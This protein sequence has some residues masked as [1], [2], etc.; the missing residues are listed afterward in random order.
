[1][2]IRYSI[3]L[4]LLIGIPSI[5]AIS[6]EQ[7]ARANYIEKY[8]GLAVQEMKKSGIP[9]SITMA[10]ALLESNDGKSEMALTAKNHFGI[11][12]HT[13]WEGRRFYYDDD[14]LNDCFRV[15]KKIKDSYRD[16]SLFLMTRSRY[17]SLFAENSLF[18][19][20]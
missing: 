16:H 17:A 9:A 1:M 6:Q 19:V 3:V 14:N 15:Y 2:I 4:V 11:K 5:H 12:C 10:Q 20:P 8:Q 18:I 7:N 13:T